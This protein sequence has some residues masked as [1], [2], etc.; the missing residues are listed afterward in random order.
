M[1]GAVK[2]CNGAVKRC[3]DAVKRC[4]D[5]VKRCND[6]G[7]R[8]IGFGYRGVVSKSIPRYRGGEILDTAVLKKN[9]LE[10][11]FFNFSPLF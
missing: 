9:F 4:N 2:R 3:N 7:C 8:G 5:A 6:Q 1:G 11:F 10:L